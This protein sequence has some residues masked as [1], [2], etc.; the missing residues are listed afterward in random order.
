ALQPVPVG[1]SGELY[2]GG[3]QLARGY[4]RRAGLTAERFVPDLY[5]S[6]AGRRMY[7]TGDV[8]RYLASGEIE[9]LGRVDQQVKLRGF[10]IE[11]GEIE[12]ALMTHDDVREATVIVYGDKATTQQLAAYIVPTYAGLE[13]DAPSDATQQESTFESKAQETIN[14]L[15]QYLKERLPDYMFPT[16]FIPLRQM[17]VTP[18]GK[19]DRKALPAPEIARGT[20]VSVPYEAPRN[21]V[22]EILAH[23][24]GE[25]LKLEKVGVHD[26]FFALGGDSIRSLQVV[27]MCRERGLY[28]TLQQL[29]Q[30]QTIAEQASVL[31]RQ[32]TDT[33]R[34]EYNREPF[35]MV[36]EADRKKIPADVE[37]AYPLSMLQGGMLY[38]WEVMPDA[39][40][41]H[42][43][44]SFHL[45]AAFDERALREATARVVARHEVLRTSFDLMTY[46]EPLQLV[47]RE[48]EMSIGVEDLH[49]LSKLEQER[50]IDDF[51]AEEKRRGFDYTRA[52]LLRFFIHIRDD[53][54]FQFTLTECHAIQDGWSLHTTL[55]EIFDNYFRLL[56]DEDLEERAAEPV[57]Y[58]DFVAMEREALA[59]KEQHNYWQNKLYGNTFTNM[60]RWPRSMRDH[61]GDGP[62]VRFR[63]VP[64]P[65]EL[66]EGVK[67]LA[68]R[69]AVPL[70]SVALAAH[71][72]VMSLLSGNRDVLTGAVSNGRPEESGGERAIGLFLNTL[73][74]RL[75]L[76]E[77]NWAD[78]VRATFDNEW[79]LLPYRRYPMAALQHGPGREQLYE[80]AFNYIHF[81]VVA[82]TLGSGDVELLGTKMV[83]ATNWALQS[84][85]SLGID[86]PH[87]DLRLEYDSDT[88]SDKQMDRVI[89]YFQNVLTAMA[90]D[91]TSRHDWQRLLSD[92][93]LDQQLH[94]W[95]KTQADY[96]RESTFAELFQQQVERTPGAI[97]VQSDDGSLTYAE[98]NRHANVLAHVLIACGVGP[99]SIVALLAERSTDFLISMLA[100]FKAGAAYLPLDPMHPVLRHL[101]VLEQS[102]A[103]VIVR[104]AEFGMLVDQIVE[105]L[106]PSQRPQVFPM[107]ASEWATR[108]HSHRLENPSLHGGPR[109]LAYVIYTS[110]STGLPKGAMVEQRGMINHLWAK[111]ND[112]GLNCSDVIAQTA[113]QCFDISVWQFLSALVMGG[114]VRIVSPE[115]GLDPVQMLKLVREDGVTVLETV[116]SLLRALVDQ[117]RQQSAADGQQAAATWGN[118]RWMVATGEALLPEL[119][120]EWFLHGS[121]SAKLLNAYGP[122]E[123]SDDVT[124]YVVESSP[125]QEQ[126][127]IPIGRA[128][129]NTQLYVLDDQMMP[130]PIGVTGELYIGG[131][132]VGRGYL[133]D[134][135]RTARRFVPH[136]HATKPGERLYRT[137]DVCRYLPNGEIEFLGR[138]DQQVKVRGYRIELGEIEAVLER[139]EEVEKSAVEAR[140][141]GTDGE[142]R[143][144]A[145]VVRRSL[146]ETA[147]ANGGNGK[148]GGNGNGAQPSGVTSRE[149][150]EYLRERL[151]EYM[152]PP[153][154]MLLDE[155]PLT[156]NGKIDRKALPAPE[157]LMAKSEV[158]YVPPRN[159][160]EQTIAKVWREVLHVK[161][162]GMND[163]FF[164]LGG[165]SI[166]MIEATSKLRV[167]LGRELSVLSMF[168]YP[169][170]SKMA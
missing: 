45:K 148:N 82:E 86:T 65:V 135:S 103:T 119:C 5:A 64:V 41:Y 99:E 161:R 149:L 70:K 54:R 136:P 91:P 49:E 138:V 61:A 134:A 63:Q 53:Q 66:S 20:L 27:G 12:A 35:A 9:Y 140:E 126:A 68:R 31:Q 71:L 6:E 36:S 37:D 83:E 59:S 147:T 90:I 10:R 102:G 107:E 137:G 170:V 139:H 16:V 22:E 21:G 1:V 123:C 51:I 74:F 129:A 42:N 69:C 73:P 78:L 32:H 46:S 151:P 62:R 164:D 168:E 30:Y 25:V 105:R 75:R 159:K 81:H 156:P 100:V 146:T 3:V 165:H 160:L 130:L 18:S 33:E 106:D 114:Q 109:N 50:R 154:I 150:W 29:F 88:W 44:N 48:A 163:N 60:P 2:I 98:L 128:L 93:E 87:I 39:A 152:V 76:P 58:R 80:T 141:D 14:A 158:V 56:K 94:Q 153:S 92:E 67:D 110:G 120:R 131:D 118:L 162:V 133:R 72:K 26:N 111:V 28:L 11:L 143:L 84:H 144:V 8:A 166:R 113:S 23:V 85:F 112:L 15:R 142:K 57:K 79:E 167:V 157:G 95:T 96:P 77:G 169:T 17:P 38:H 132:G 116:P 127:R 52:P 121:P 43:V 104:S 155:M 55:A 47:H 124:H 115:R 7:R 108:A 122:T 145:Y 19:V 101:Q 34:R 89:H 125:T 24:W 40:L 13:D 4:W 117:A 97:A